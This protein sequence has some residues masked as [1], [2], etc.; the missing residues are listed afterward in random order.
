MQG[1]NILY[2]VGIADLRL[3]HSQ[4]RFLF[5]KVDFDIPTL[6]VALQQN[7][8]IQERVG[9]DQ[10][11]WLPVEQLRAFPQ[12]ISQRRNH[13]QLERVL[14][15]GGAPQQIL[16]DFDPQAMMD[17]G[18]GDLDVLP[19]HGFIGPQLFRGRRGGTVVARVAARFAGIG[20]RRQDVQLGIFANAPDQDGV[21]GE[22][23]QDRGIGIAAID[24]QMKRTM[25]AI[26][27]G[28]EPAAESRNLLR[29]YIR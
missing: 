25:E 3:T 28:I 11:S 14:Q 12:A 2:R 9:T 24:K 6:D 16:Q 29:G 17:A 13:H 22:R 1:G 26:G 18:D 19:G 23:F 15:A 4:P 20:F 8:Q 27:F 10:K 21:G 7:E 5:A